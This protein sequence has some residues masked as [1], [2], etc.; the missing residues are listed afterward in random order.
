M[1]AEHCLE[2][3]LYQKNKLVLNDFDQTQFCSVLFFFGELWKK[4]Y[5]NSNLKPAVQL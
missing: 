2:K 3:R 4:V 5:K 1:S